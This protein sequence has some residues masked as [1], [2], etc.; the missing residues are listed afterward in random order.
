MRTIADFILAELAQ[1]R[2]VIA[3]DWRLY[4][5]YARVARAQGYRLPDRQSL[6]KQIQKMCSESQIERLSDLSGVYQV[7]VPFASSLPRP[8]EA[9]IQESNPTA[10]FSHFTAIAFHQL[11]DEIPQSI[12]VSY[13]PGISIRI[14]L[15]TTPDDW[16]DAP[17]PRLRYPKTVTP[18]KMTATDEKPTSRTV[19][20]S[21]IKPEWDFGH[22][23]GFVT[24]TPIYV[25]NLERTL[26]DS[27]RSPE[28]CLGLS[29]VFRVWRRAADQIDVDRIVQYVDRINQGLLKQRVGLILEKLEKNHPRLNEWADHATRGSSAKL[30]ATSEF[31]SVYS[32]RWRLSLN[33]PDSTLS[34]LEA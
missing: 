2:C 10:V 19:V 4:V 18:N 26:I 12:F 20:W 14:P 29:E 9:I 21:K 32:E 33:V 13:S 5:Y 1:E 34:Q 24:Q 23:I 15:G 3:A 31:S 8:D 27:I 17:K 30:D 28:K 25:T 22:M 6:S 16:V 11:T 7:I